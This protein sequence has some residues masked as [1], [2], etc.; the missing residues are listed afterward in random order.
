MRS[1][2]VPTPP[3]LTRERAAAEIIEAICGKLDEDRDAEAIFDLD[4][5]HLGIEI[6]VL[7]PILDAYKRYIQKGTKSCVRHSR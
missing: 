2:V 1:L 3:A 5:D 6:R 7:Y 4:N